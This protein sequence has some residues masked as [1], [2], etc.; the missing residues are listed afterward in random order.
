[1]DF[2]IV[3][4]TGTCV[5]QLL[6]DL[7]VYRQ[8]DVVVLLTAAGQ[9]AV[10]R[11]IPRLEDPVLVGVQRLQDKRKIHKSIFISTVMS[12]RRGFVEA[13]QKKTDIYTNESTHVNPLA[14]RGYNSDV[15][16]VF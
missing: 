5:E 8:I 13:Q 10:D 12:T 7:L 9:V 16:L 4:H 11:V 6:V 3:R 14:Y 2:E 1:M 15:N